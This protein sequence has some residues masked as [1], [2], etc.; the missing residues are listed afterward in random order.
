MSVEARAALE[1]AFK[2]HRLKRWLVLAGGLCVLAI[3]IAA[4]TGLGVQSLT[5]G[6]S[7]RA[8][9]APILPSAWLGDLTTLQID[10]VQK[11]RAPRTLLAA[12][13]GAS[14]ALA[15]GA[16]QG[17]TRNPLVSPFTLGVSS[18]AAFGAS[19]AI[20]AGWGELARSGPYWTV[21]A[22]FSCALAC[23]ALVLGFSAMR[24]VTA[25]MLIL[26][27]V[28]LNYLFS[29]ATTTVQ[30]VATEQQLAAIIQWSF[31]SL[32]GAAWIE[33]IIVGTILLVVAPILLAHAWAL[34]A[35]AAGGDEVAASLGFSVTRTRAVVTVGAV[36]LTAG[37]V[38]FA[39]VIGFVGLVAPHIARLLIGGD[40][41]AFLPFA[42]V[43]G[44]VLVVTADL[45]GRLAF[46]PV[47]IPVGIVVAYLGVPLFLHLLLARRREMLL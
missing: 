22:A 35:F 13:G 44:A 32:N 18:A 7:L 45:I 6:Q 15:G 28:G 10:V 17:V 8:L 21:V 20:L 36:L 3:A 38:S 43:T 29:A 33:V 24:G 31:G 16:L 39:G 27:G 42:A 25:M 11:L 12:I 47:I 9:L 1:Q 23:A 37:I 5:F 46:A 40:H 14:L 34:N 41:R 4:S 2:R 26:G 19:L 30:F